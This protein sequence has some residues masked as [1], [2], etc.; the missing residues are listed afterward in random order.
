MSAVNGSRFAALDR[1]KREAW[2][3]GGMQFELR[4]ASGLAVSQSMKLDQGDRMRLM[5]RS[6]VYLDGEPAIQDDAALD[7][8]LE[9]IAMDDF[10]ALL[11]RLTALNEG[12]EGNP[13]A[14]VE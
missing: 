6:C 2:S 11:A 8:F 5:L 1:R 14:S 7:D 4:E 9:H 10:Y 3:C 12:A 13:A